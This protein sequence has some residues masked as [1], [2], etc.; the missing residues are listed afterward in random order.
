MSNLSDE[1][2]QDLSSSKIF[3]TDN[4]LVETMRKSFEFWHKTFEDS[5]I[6]ILLVWKKATESN[7]E[8]IK[9]I[10]EIW[11]DNKNQNVKIPM[12]EFLEFW[13]NATREPDF[14]KAKKSLQEWQKFWKNTTDDQFKTYVKILEMLETYW[15]NE[16]SK[17]IE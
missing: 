7:F 3:T 4:L 12:M 6:N 5:P 14:E 8:I 10:S 2:K 11:K 13:S 1:N 16:Q 15:K 17:A 9:K